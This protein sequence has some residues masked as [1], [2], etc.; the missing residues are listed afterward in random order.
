MDLFKE[1][2]PSILQNKNYL[3]KEEKDEKLYNPYIV[4]KA[5][6]YHID[7]VMYANQMNTNFHLDKRLQYDYFI[8]TV[9]AKKR[10]F[11]QWHKQTKNDDLE[12][13]KLYYG[14]SNKKAKEALKVLTE[15]Q[16]EMIRQKT[17]I[18]E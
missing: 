13:V 14:Y 16:I 17:K 2:L 10:S 8:N 15:E 1:L 3:L 5:L 4:N 12:S 18:G 11:K 9:R 7:C 6:S